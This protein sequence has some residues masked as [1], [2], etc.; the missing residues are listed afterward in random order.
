MTVAAATKTVASGRT[1]RISRFPR[2]IKSAWRNDS[3]AMRPSTK[4]S[5]IG[6]GSKSNLRI[7]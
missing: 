5:T 2:D 4:A 3:S 7:T 1:R 6:A